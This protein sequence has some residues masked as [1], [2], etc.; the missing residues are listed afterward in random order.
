M[1][2]QTRL[3]LPYIKKGSRRSI[4]NIAS[5][6]NSDTLLLKLY[7]TLRLPLSV[8]RYCA[9]TGDLSRLIVAG[10]ATPEQLQDAWQQICRQYSDTMGDHEYRLYLSLYL[11]I[12]DLSAEIQVIETL[13]AV[14]RKIY[15]P[16]Y[17]KALN[18]MLNTNFVFE[19][20]EQ[21][22]Y[23]KLLNRCIVRTGS[24]KLLLEIKLR[25]FKA[26]EAKFASGGGVTDEYFDS[27]LITLTDFAKVR[28]DDTISTYEFCERF[29]RMMK[30]IEKNNK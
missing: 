7:T 11:N 19:W 23:H 9:I 21:E 15:L 30:H 14:M 16:Q 25:Q 10:K 17:G 18:K 5:Q 28:I 20:Q 26:I 12:S 8:Y 1:Q 24:T 2:K 29:K 13:V 22:A 3:T 27:L 4:A 6:S